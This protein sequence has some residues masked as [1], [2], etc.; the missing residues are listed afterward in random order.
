MKNSSLQET[1]II[2]LTLIPFIYLGV[3]YM[4]LPDSVPMHWNAKGEMDRM[5]N[6]QELWIIPILISALMYLLFKFIP[7]I[8]PKGQIKKMGNKYGHLRLGMTVI[9]TALSIGIIYS[10]TTYETGDKNIPIWI[11]ITIGVLFLIIGNY[12]PAMKP[13]YFVGIRTPWTLENETVWRKTHRLAARLFI[14]TGIIIIITA[15]FLPMEWITYITTGTAIAITIWTII[16]SY[17][18]FK[19]LQ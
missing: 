7:K 11:F 1:V 17:T 8:D 10:S 12:M 18:L 3:I 9:L 13:N 6:K 14:A 19:K 2:I 5:G 16:Y 15:L 4:D